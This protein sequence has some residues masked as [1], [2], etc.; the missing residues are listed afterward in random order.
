VG[1]DLV[2]RQPS[3][4]AILPS[5]TDCIDNTGSPNDEG[6]SFGYFDAQHDRSIS[7]ISEHG[8]HSDEWQQGYRDGF[9]AGLNDRAEGID[10]NPC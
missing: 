3:P 9:Q 4:L 7:S 5:G 1:H 8:N 6:Y 10:R 2:L